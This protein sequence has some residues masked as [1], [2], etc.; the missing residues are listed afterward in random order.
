MVFVLLIPTVIAIRLRLPRLR[1]VVESICM[2]PLVVSPIAL[3]SGINT[4]LRWGSDNLQTTPFRVT[5]VLIAER[6]ASR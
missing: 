6:R 1:S 4:V 3:I 5:L 2:V